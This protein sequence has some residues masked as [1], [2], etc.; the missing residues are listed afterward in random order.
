MLPP[1]PCKD[2]TDTGLGQQSALKMFF[3]CPSH[4]EISWYTKINDTTETHLAHNSDQ[5]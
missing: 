1:V 3:N 4:L 2:S 5:F